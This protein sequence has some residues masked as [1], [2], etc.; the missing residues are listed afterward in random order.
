[1][2]SS[3]HIIGVVLTVVV[4]LIVGWLS[5]RNVKDERSFTTGGSAGSWMVCGAFLTT[6]AGGQ[7]T[8]GTAQ[9][10]FS[11]GISAW[12]FT[13][14]AAL[15][16]VVLA[17]FYAGPLRRSGCSTLLEIVGREYGHKVEAVGS[18]LFLIGIF[19][20]IVAQVLTSSAMIGSLFNMGTL[21]SL[22]TGAVL[23]ML[24]VIFGGIKS[25]GAG[26]IV[27]L[28]LLYCG[29]VATG[30]IVWHMAGG[31][32]GFAQGIDNI[33]KS[34]TIASFNGLDSV[35][36]IHHR[37]GSMVARGPMKDL[38]GCL[39]LVLGVVSTQTYAQCI[40]SGRT[41]AKARNGALLCAF[42]IPVIG[43]AC[44]LVGLY[45]RGHYVTADE[46]H[47]LEQAGETLPSGVGVIAS[48]AQAFPS[49]ILRHLPAW[50]GGLMLGAL[51]INILG[52][53]SGLML[54]ASTILVRDVI[55]NAQRKWWS[56]KKHMSQLLETRLSIVVLLALAVMVAGTFNGSFINDLGFLSLGLRAV[57]IIFP[58]S[59]ALWAPGRFTT[60][61]VMISMV[62]GTAMML[63][64][65]LLSLPGDAV[66][67]GLA[68]SLLALLL[69]SNKSTH[70]PGATA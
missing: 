15:G 5:A 16:G 70:S 37:Y 14:G 55:A 44:T 56:G 40:W 3:T 2:I 32:D 64:A 69:F 41:T 6:L 62:A 7:S 57:A 47:A 27:K 51:L 23:I 1:M 22:I 25:A 33:Y 49:F 19:I 24:F 35:E 36:S 67:Y 20:S 63:A 34:T 13:L 28:I 52:C 17:L 39:S 11:Y 42:F 60:R 10:A 58:L 66:F 31:I 48:S 54:G 18:I 30:I 53:G 50:F 21:W 46:L 65:N 43:A 59:F 38:G 29:S 45:M 9:L 12:W 68:T 8:V 26:G 4:L 61:G